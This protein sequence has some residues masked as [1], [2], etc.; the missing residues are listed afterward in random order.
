M[1][2][3]VKSMKEWKKLDWYKDIGL[4][5]TSIFVIGVYVFAKR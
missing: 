4:L 3:D 2:F 5:E 1:Y